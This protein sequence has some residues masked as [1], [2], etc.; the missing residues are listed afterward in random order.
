MKTSTMQRTATV[1]IMVLGG[2][3]ALPDGFNGSGGTGGA[4]GSPRSLVEDFESDSGGGAGGFATSLFLHDTS[5]A[6]SV[7]IVDETFSELAAPY[8][9]S[10]HALF[11]A[12]GP[13]VVTFDL[14]AGE[15]VRAVSVW[16]NTVS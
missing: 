5:A 13:D 14:A 2:C 11:V 7:Q 12:T 15:S 9:S 16:V 3:N 6:G 4:G 1:W 10:S 8:I